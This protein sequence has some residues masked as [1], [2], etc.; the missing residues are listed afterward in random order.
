MTV[1]IIKLSI[2]ALF[3]ASIAFAGDDPIKLH[4]F[5]THSRLVFRMDEGVQGQWKDTKNGFELYF[6]GIGLSDLGIPLGVEEQWIKNEQRQLKDN[7]L[8]GLEFVEAVG[9]LRVIGKW[10]F[11]KGDKAPAS[12]KME[13]FTYHQKN[14]ARYVIDFWLKDGPTVAEIRAAKKKA[15]KITAIKKT[16]ENS[17]IRR[18]RRI[19]SEKVKAEAED[20]TK[21]CTQ[22][23]AEG[24]DVFLPF[25]PLHKKVNFGRWFPTTTA[26]SE[27]IYLEPKGNSQDAQYL[28]LALRLYRQGNAGLTIRTLDFLEAEYPTSTFI[29]ESR[30][31]RANA[32]IKLGLN[33]EAVRVLNELITTAKDSGVALHA[34]MYVAVKHISSEAYLPALEQFLWLTNQYPSHRLNWVFHLGAAESLYALKQ[35]ERASKEYQWVILNAPDKRVQAEA[36]IRLGDLY[37]ERRQYE[38]ALASYFQAFR[39]YKDQ[40]EGFPAV[41]INRAETLYWIGEYERA[42]N[43]FTEFLDKFPSNTAG[44][45]ASFRL[46]E[47]FGRREGS[48]NVAKSRYWFNETINRFPYSPGAT[49]AREYLI[50]CGNHAGFDK[51]AAEKFYSTEAMNFNG[52]GELWMQ[53]YPEFRAL[54]KVRAFVTLSKEET[55]VDAAIQEILILGNSEI[56]PVLTDLLGKLFRKAILVMIDKGKKYEALAFYHEKSTAI[57]RRI[58]ATTLGPPDYLLKLSQAASDLGLGKKAKELAELYEK[59]ETASVNGQHREPATASGIDQKATQAET[60]FTKAKALWMDTKKAA[61]TEIRAMLEKVPA[62]SEYSY[63]KEIILGLL[64]EGDEKFSSALSHA[65]RAQL[66]MPGSL[67]E[68]NSEKIRVD[69]WVATL[70]AKAGN[71]RLAVETFRKVE[72]LASNQEK[73]DFEKAGPLGVSPLPPVDVI[74]LNEAEVLAQ[75]GKWGESAAAYARVF[76]NASVGNRALYEYSRALKKIGGADNLQKAQVALDKLAESKV[77]DFWRKLAREALAG[78]DSKT[79]LQTNGEAKE[80]RK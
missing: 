30:F 48:E 80:G 13:K 10:E 46:G 23:L 78:K 73:S 66:L 79:K 50:P 58:G 57:P 43:A 54:S 33:S 31:L 71:P 26:D 12:P 35:T 64:D 47:I 56:R 29:L 67:S 18:E 72:R 7:R 74:V 44:W 55:A 45:R 36:A 3:L 60:D 16:E 77:D 25:T 14:P 40:S 62:E 24:R 69:Y 49:L 76:E 32:M 8:L 68:T 11:P 22:P 15:Q 52:G 27:Y 1:S 38:Q 34:G 4:S 9:G 17:N 5:K 19:A 2:I 42:E 59:N 75:L 20:I 39:Y 41:F 28:R 65:L 6:K 21:F 51:A 63:E 37:L 53:R 70:Q 61:E